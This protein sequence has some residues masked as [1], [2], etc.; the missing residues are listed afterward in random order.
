MVN[1]TSD[2]NE[3]NIPL[4]YR[5]QYVVQL[6]GANIQFQNDASRILDAKAQLNFS[7]ANIVLGIITAFNLG[8]G[9]IEHLREYINE[10]P[11]LT[12]VVVGIYA[13]TIF[14]SIWALKP[15]LQAGFPL[16][17]NAE[18]IKSWTECKTPDFYDV[19]TK[20]YEAIYRK[21]ETANR[22]KGQLVQ[23]SHVLIA[24]EIAVVFGAGARLFP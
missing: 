19:L 11:A 20:S 5:Q 9:H 2:G 18:D 24:L 4:T 3:Q 7:I 12:V 17:P 21:N 22:C 15:R 8:V 16:E 13:F 1:I 10:R 6:L 14:C 23:L